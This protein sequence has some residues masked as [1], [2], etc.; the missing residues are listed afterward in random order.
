MSSSL[1]LESGT[2]VRVLYMQLQTFSSGVG[3]SLEDASQEASTVGHARL[4]VLDGV[5][6]AMLVLEGL[7]LASWLESEVKSERGLTLS[8]STSTRPGPR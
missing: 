2:Q 6:W 8:P 1:S 3:G 4:A 5:Y 7:I